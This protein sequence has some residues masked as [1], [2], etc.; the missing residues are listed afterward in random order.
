MKAIFINFTSGREESA[1]LDT[2]LDDKARA[3]YLINEAL[4]EGVDIILGIAMS[5]K[6][7]ERIDSMILPKG[8]RR[9]LSPEYKTLSKGRKA[10]YSQL[11]V[12]Y[13][14]PNIKSAQMIRFDDSYIHDMRFRYN[15]L[16][17]NNDF[18]LRSIHIPAAREDDPKYEFQ[19][20]RRQRFLSFEYG[21][22]TIPEDTIVV[23]DFNMAN[24][25]SKYKKILKGKTYNGTIQLDHVMV[26]PGMEER[27]KATNFDPNFDLT[28]KITDH[29][30]IL[31][32]ID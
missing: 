20:E 30:P 27:V 19:L 25:R 11:A 24:P 3:E 31:I 2:N 13:V 28:G 9:A 18:F 4:E 1:K 17:L 22:Q 15:T 26:S 6:V 10:R 29:S 5:Q 23:G 8:W 12:S 7:I 21:L 14:S 32:T 16:K